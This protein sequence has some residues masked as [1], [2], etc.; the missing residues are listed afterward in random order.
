[1]IRINLNFR[2]GHKCTTLCHHKVLFT[3][4]YSV[5]IV[6]VN[7]KS[8]ELEYLSGFMHVYLVI[9]RYTIKIG[10]ILSEEVD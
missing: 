6:A 2:V 10:P 3:L 8:V 7:Q 4:H 1:M 9:S 5:F